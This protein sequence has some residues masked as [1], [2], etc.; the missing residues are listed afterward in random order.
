MPYRFA[1][2]DAMMAA[3][4]PETPIQPREMTVSSDVTVVFAIRS[5][6]GSTPL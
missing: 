4:G 1:A 2:G 6:G 5:V 3:G